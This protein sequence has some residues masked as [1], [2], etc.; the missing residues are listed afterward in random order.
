[1]SD[2]G[3]RVWLDRELNEELKQAAA[4]RGLSARIMMERMLAEGLKTEVG[5]QARVAGMKADSQ[6][7]RIDRIVGEMQQATGRVDHLLEQVGTMI[8]K[9]LKKEFD[10]LKAHVSSTGGTAHLRDLLKQLMAEFQR[11]LLA[12]LDEVKNA[13]SQSAE[14]RTTHAGLDRLAAQQVR[15]R[16]AAAGGAGAV[17]VLLMAIAFLSADTPPTRWMA[18][19]LTGQTDSAKAG[20]T[21]IGNGW[22][23]G[24]MLLKTQVLIDDSDKF[25][26][27]LTGCLRR[28]E[29]ARVSFSCTLDMDPAPKAPEQ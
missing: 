19:R 5:R 2:D 14:H 15:S 22:A 18:T 17:L 9:Q 7:D 10:A 6:L 3:V 13:A 25:K 4:A 23:T 11:T 21:L 27:S 12:K 20:F 26:N 29:Q 16:R 8:P 24:V 1:M 28:A